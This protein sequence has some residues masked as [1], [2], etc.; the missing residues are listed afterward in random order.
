MSFDPG[1]IV[2]L[3]QTCQTLYDYYRDVKQSSVERRRLLD[4]V[5]SLQSA[6][7]ALQKLAKVGD[8]ASAEQLAQLLGPSQPFYAAL[9][10]TLADVE[11]VL[12]NGVPKPT[13]KRWKVLWGRLFAALWWTAEKAEVKALLC[14]LERQKSRILIA[15]QHDIFQKQ[16]DV[17]HHLSNEDRLKIAAFIS[18]SDFAG[19][20]INLLEERLSGTGIWVLQHPD[21][22]AWRD[23]GEA[24]RTLW[25]YGHP[26]AG[27]SV[28]AALIVDYLQSTSNVVLSVFCR[29]TS[30]NL[31][32]PFPVLRGL[33]R[34]LIEKTTN[35][36]S[37]ICD[38]YSTK[39]IP[40]PDTLPEFLAEV[41]AVH[42][43]PIYIVLDA[44]DECKIALDLLRAIQ[45]LGPLFRILITSRPI[46][47][48]I[49]ET[50]SIQIRA[51]NDDILIAVNTTLSKLKHAWL[52]ETLKDMIRVQI[53]DKADGMFLLASLQLR[54]LERDVTCQRDVVAVLDSLPRT[55]DD[56]YK[57]TFQRIHEQG[58]RTSELACRALA[59]VALR[60]PLLG[61]SYL[62]DLLAEGD[63]TQ[64]TDIE[65]VLQCCHGLVDFNL[66]YGPVFVVVRL[67]YVRIHHCALVGTLSRK[68]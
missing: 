60:S 61:V 9:Q 35:V 27:K 11:T 52:D 7:E 26:G 63:I 49:Q 51:S 22:V 40:N 29:Y 41:A 43:R 57:L 58:Q 23:S 54:E 67:F 48:E 56:A 59:L 12:R 68:F 5:A 46:F 13:A 6:L 2:T 28:M 8:P 55:L 18:P 45:H 34:Q 65:I 33:L 20:R 44:L 32:T 38:L 36:P 66:E 47:R 14:D 1:S 10:K 24:S 15:L 37:T 42:A 53:V 64:Y 16:N 4:E 21:F 25:C 17:K 30:D 19:H 3:I 50:P 62:Q 31:K 39:T